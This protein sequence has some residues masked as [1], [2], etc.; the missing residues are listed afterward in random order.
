M[1]DPIKI[2]HKFKNNN[3]RIQY[4]LYLF[5]GQLVDD[6][7]MRALNLIKDK[8]FNDSIIMLNA[9]LLKKLELFYGEFWYNKIFITEHVFFEKKEAN[10]MKS[11]KDKIIRVR[12]KSYF[13]KHYV[14]NR[15]RMKNNLF[16]YAS[17]YYNNLLARNKIKTLTKKKKH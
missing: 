13:E 4:H 10:N 3:R 9:K 6:D 5:I 2:I 7:V 15:K 1:D 11:L 12:G 16:S 14:K 17:N 8:P